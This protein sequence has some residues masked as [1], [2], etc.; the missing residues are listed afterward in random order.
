MLDLS[1]N[2]KYLNFENFLSSI[3]KNTFLDKKDFVFNINKSLP[4]L[5]KTKEG[6]LL[7]VVDIFHEKNVD[8]LKFLDDGILK[9]IE[10]KKALPFGNEIVIKKFENGLL[11]SE[12]GCIKTSEVELTSLF[13]GYLLV[14][15]VAFIQKGLCS[16][17]NDLEGPLNNVT[18]KKLKNELVLE[19]Y[20]EFIKSNKKIDFKAFREL[21]SKGE[22]KSR[23]EFYINGKN[24]LF[25]IAKKEGD[26]PPFSIIEEVI[27]GE[28]CF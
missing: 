24:Y 22:F 10:I 6:Y 28:F 7:H 12:Y 19:G 3:K 27:E 11:I 4:S 2:F 21:D 16:G 26:N 8:K 23:V 9:L 15:M 5:L 25:S 1:S 14:K 13:K 18:F 17:L 20:F